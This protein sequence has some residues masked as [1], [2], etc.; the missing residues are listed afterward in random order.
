MLDLT[1]AQ[2]LKMEAGPLLDAMVDG[3]QSSWELR[4]EVDKKGTNW[5]V[6]K[7][8]RLRLAHVPPLVTR[9]IMVIPAKDGPDEV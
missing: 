6:M 8:P 3:L 9:R 5:L 7:F 1:H 2:V 4:W